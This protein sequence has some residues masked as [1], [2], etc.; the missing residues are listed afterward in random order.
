MKANKYNHSKVY[1]ISSNEIGKPF[2][3]IGSTTQ[4]LAA[5]LHFHKFR[6]KNCNS[7]AYQFFKSIDWNIGIYLIK[8]YNLDNIEQLKKEEDTIIR[9]FFDD[10]YCLNVRHAI[11]DKDHRSQY[12]KSY[13]ENN[14]E[15]ITEQSKLYYQQNKEI[16]QQKTKNWRENNHDKIHAYYERTK[17]RQKEISRQ[18]YE[19]NGMRNIKCEC[20]REITK[21]ALRR[22]LESKIHFDIIRKKLLTNNLDFSA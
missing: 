18:N 5:R 11:L 14:K 12:K 15:K 21:K 22:H 10:P 8:E 9:T 20:G 4:S 3:Y 17:D 7:R 19:K 6:S 2:F 1:R 13:A 16:I